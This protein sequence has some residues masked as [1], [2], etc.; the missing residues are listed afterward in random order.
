MTARSSTNNFSK[1]GT[2]YL[3]K[4]RTL[5]PLIILISIFSLLSYPLLAGFVV[6]YMHAEVARMEYREAHNGAF[7][8]EY[9]KLRD[10]SELL[11]GLSIM[12]VVICFIMLVALFF[13]SYNVTRK[14]FRWLYNK[15]IVDMDYSLP[16]SDDT[17]FCGDLLASLSACVVPHLIAIGLGELI[18]AFRPRIDELTEVLK[19]HIIEQVLFSGLFACIMFMAYVL[20]VVAICGRKAETALYPLVITFAVPIIHAVCLWLAYS[21]VYGY[22]FAN[23]VNDFNSLSYT[24]PLGFVVMSIAYLFISVENFGESVLPLFRAAYGIPA[25]IVT[26][27]LF[28]AAYFLIRSRRAERVG[29]PFAFNVVKFI[30]PAVVTFTIVSP[31]MG[32]IGEIRREASDYDSITVHYEG[33]VIAM[34][35]ITFVVYVIMELISGKGFRKFHITLAKYAATMGVCLLICVGLWNAHGFGIGNYV[36]DADKVQS[37]SFDIGNYSMS[38]VSFNSKIEDTE[39]IKAFTQAH[40]DM[41]KEKLTYYTSRYIN[42]TYNMKNGE[43]VHREYKLTAEQYN[44]WAATVLTSEAYFNSYSY[45]GLLDWSGGEEVTQVLD[46]RRDK[47]YNTRIHG[48]DLLNAL[49]SDC[50]N[51]SVEQMYGTDSTLSCELR[52][53]YVTALGYEGITYLSVYCWMTE[54]L[55]LLQSN[56]V[57]IT[58]AYSPIDIT[59]YRT[60]FLVEYNADQTRCYFDEL[61]AFMMCGDN[62]LTQSELD[63]IGYSSVISHNIV[64]DEKEYYDKYGMIYDD[65][66]VVDFNCVKLDMQSE[67]FLDLIQYC[68]DSVPLTYSK[69]VMYSIV[70]TSAENAHDVLSGGNAYGEYHISEDGYEIASQLFSQLS[71]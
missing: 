36:P 43:T 10:A 5:R 47:V 14:N 62:S 41:S 33:F 45:N 37:V 13:M 19:T 52:L 44:D 66:C 11:G 26:L 68:G 22:E 56:G 53:E 24:S 15:T 61:A 60:A 31:F 42:F 27:A 50:Y 4:L 18:F 64:P 9:E 40:K 69:D 30:I 54:T 57:D 34:L 28:A 29:Q 67:A 6:P 7:D 23:S 65:K 35:I 46:T 32:V 3:Y 38:S 49:R 59:D 12:A 1:L 17:R 16:I 21:D 8:S 58:E 20:F 63:E 2:Y 39:N 70:L 51:A 25:V 48:E 55:S 71:A